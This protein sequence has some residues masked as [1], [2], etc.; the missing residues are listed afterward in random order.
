MKVVGMPNQLKRL[1]SPVIS[2]EATTVRA[3]AAAT[4]ETST[5]ARDRMTHAGL[6]QATAGLSPSVLGEAWTDWIVHLS[7]S[8][9]KQMQLREQATRNGQAFLAAWL[10]LP[11]KVVA[12]DD[13]PEGRYHPGGKALAMADIAASEGSWGE[14]SA[15]RLGKRSGRPV[16]LPQ[17]GAH[18]GVNRAICDAPGT[19]VMQR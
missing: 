16:P 11:P 7:T 17:M 4:E 19:Y 8:S 13:G 18:T 15:D 3:T 5:E 10:G 9:G 6:A 2:S 14:A 1:T 12:P